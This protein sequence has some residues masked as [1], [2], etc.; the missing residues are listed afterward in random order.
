MRKLL[1]VNKRVVET[2][3]LRGDVKSKDILNSAGKHIGL[4]CE[5][6][7]VEITAPTKGS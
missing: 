7:S 4:Y 5:K 3:Q 2:L 1:N 6:T